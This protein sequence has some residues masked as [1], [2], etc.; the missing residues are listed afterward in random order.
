MRPDVVASTCL[1]RNMEC[2]RPILGRLAEL[3]RKVND[4]MSAQTV[5]SPEDTLAFDLESAGGLIT[6]ESFQGCLTLL[7]NL[8]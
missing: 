6:W 7:P 3:F 5:A 2:A 4:A 1:T 8:F